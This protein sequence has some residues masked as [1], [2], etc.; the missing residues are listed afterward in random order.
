MNLRSKCQAS[1]I[2]LSVKDILICESISHLVIEAKFGEGDED[3]ET[4]KPFA[5]TAWQT[6][7]IQKEVD[8]HKTILSLVTTTTVPKLVR[9]IEAIV[10]QHPMLR[11]RFARDAEGIWQ[12]TITKEL[13]ASYKFE[14]RTLDAAADVKTFMAGVQG[15]LDV[16]TGPLFSVY[17][18][19]STTESTQQTLALAI[20][21]VI[22]DTASVRIILQDICELLQG[23]MMTTQSEASFQSSI[24]KDAPM[25]TVEPPATDLTHWGIADKGMLNKNLVDST[26]TLPSGVTCT[27][28]GAANK[29][30]S[31]QPTDILVAV[32]SKVWSTIFGR[33]ASLALKNE[34]RTN[35]VVGQFH[36]IRHLAEPTTDELIQLISEVKDDRIFQDVGSSLTATLPETVEMLVESIDQCALGIG[37][38]LNRPSV[39]IPAVVTV[40]V[41]VANGEMTIKFSHSSD[42]AQQET[43]A[44]FFSIVEQT[45]PNVA[46]SLSN[47]SRKPTLADFPLLDMD[48]PDLATLS[49]VFADI[50]VSYSNVEAIVPCTPLQQRMLNTQKQVSGAWESDSAHKIISSGHIENDIMRI[51]RAWQ[52][53]TTRHEAM[54]TI[55]IPSVSHSHGS[56]QLVLK[57]YEPT[58]SV[59]ECDEA[60]VQRIIAN[61][62]TVSHLS[63]K[64]HVGFTLFRTPSSLYSKIEL[65]HTMHDG[66][67]TRNIFHDLVLA[68]QD[69]LPEGPAAG[70]REYV[71][72]V[73]KQDLSASD[74]FWDQYLDNVPSCHIPRKNDMTFEKRSNVLTP[75]QI[76]IDLAS[77]VINTVCRKYKV[78]SATLFQAAW[79]LVLR[80]LAA[81]DDVLFGYLTANREL[82]IPGID[83]LVGPFINMLACRLNVKSD[84]KITNVLK[85][86]HDSFLSTLEHQHSFVSSASAKESLDGER[87]FNTCM[88]IEY[89]SGGSQASSATT[90]DV[91]IPSL[92][93]ESVYE[94][95]APEFEVALGVLVGDK[96][97]KVQ[98]GYHAGVMEESMM[99]RLAR[100]YGD[101][102]KEMIEGDGLSGE[103][104][105]LKALVA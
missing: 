105:D 93:F 76:Q 15:G 55:F 29:A 22:A 103:V 104:R 67:S 62:H 28:L 101:V 9:A 36:H 23:K 99:D 53:V 66:M 64:P 45:I 91:K 94:S 43:L 14:A 60:N 13:N 51:Q 16:E 61:H 92:A 57:S 20:H 84:D 47:M 35:R 82:N 86:T 98:L 41:V 42:L 17:L 72:W 2:S 38:H 27:L 97:V 37:E 85:Q 79:V 19:D 73:A 46:L 49:K 11:A 24:S 50:N 89:A 32:L 8:A 71:K 26:I 80:T 58:V 52:Q 1:G 83:G 44:T 100:M 65:S 5:L 56:D 40:S 18:F 59:I 25:I 95:R 90:E 39:D 87:P 6:A 12:Q 74:E 33:P 81:Q 96:S 7:L 88:S 68:Y 102:V 78:T 69:L 75:I 4:G 48:Y 63:Y 77:E 70:F 10:Q 54:R 21:P 34:S 3:E 31:T 30:L